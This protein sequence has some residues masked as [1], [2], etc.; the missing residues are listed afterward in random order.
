[1][2][3]IYCDTGI[4]WVLV[5][6]LGLILGSLTNAVVYRLPKQLMA[7]WRVEAASLLKV[8]NTSTEQLS[9]WSLFSRSHCPKCLHQISWWQ[10]VPLLS[11]I[12]LRGRC[13][14]CKQG[15][16]LR[17]PVVELLGVVVMVMAFFR[18][19]PTVKFLFAAIFGFYLLV[20]ALIDFDT[21][22]LP[23]D[24][25]WPLFMVG[26]FASQFS[27]F[28]PIQDAVW[29]AIGGYYCLWSIYW[30]FFWITKKHGFGFG[31]FKFMCALGAWLGWQ[32]IPLIIL[33]SCVAALG[34]SM[35]CFLLS[36]K[37]GYSQTEGG[38]F[39]WQIPFG[40][41]LALAGW[42]AM[43]FVDERYLYSYLLPVH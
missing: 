40:P 21:Q 2:L 19:G 12:Y 28:V 35:I 29:G 43:F 10:N 8:D 24:I 1:M 5:V 26:L 17:Y 15:I 25:T 23:D 39:R 32:S 6:V 9:D 37:P 36:Y 41:Y 7:S 11:Y 33:G 18:F 16:S 31:D 30:V 22:L 4:F 20:A 3:D 38:F 13:F 27:L 34:V 42:V 14:F